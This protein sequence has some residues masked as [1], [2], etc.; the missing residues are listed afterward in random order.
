MNYTMPLPPTK[1]VTTADAA[2][3]LASLTPYNNSYI[4]HDKKY[5]YQQHPHK[6]TVDEK[7]SKKQLK[8]SI[9]FNHSNRPISPRQATSNPYID[10]AEVLATT[11]SFVRENNKKL[12][13]LSDEVRSDGQSSDNDMDSVMSDDSM[14]S[15]QHSGSNRD[16]ENEIEGLGFQLNNMEQ[17][18]KEQIRGKNKLIEELESAWKKSEKHVKKKSLEIER[19][20]SQ[21]EVAKRAI[22]ELV[23]QQQREIESNAARGSS[24]DP[25]QAETIQILE[26]ELEEKDKAIEEL[27]K[28]IQTSNKRAIELKEKDKKLES[29]SNQLLR[30]QTLESEWQDKQAAFD[31]LSDQLE[32]LK[33]REVELNEKDAIIESLNKRLDTSQ[34]VIA[35]L[36]EKHA[37]HDLLKQLRLKDHI[38]DGLTQQVE[39]I[40]ANIKDKDDDIAILTAHLAEEKKKM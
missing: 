16:F 28:K 32:I 23:E 20:E 5:N 6:Y 29:I 10:V 35:E 18:Y 31:S 22:S 34:R 39:N 14:D 36:R 13:R 33:K 37:P 2:A 3:V 24:P 15:W 25:E 9:S 17:K 38:I 8:R 12:D 21:L 1:V 27:N 40:D 19:L 30:Y 26:Q 4:N 7:Q 11:V